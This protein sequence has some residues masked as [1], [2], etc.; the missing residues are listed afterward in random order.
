MI[1]FLFLN[2]KVKVNIIMSLNAKMAH[3]THVRRRSPLLPKRK[4]SGQKRRVCHLKKYV[5]LSGK[6]MVPQTPEGIDFLN[7]THPLYIYTET[8]ATFSVAYLLF[9]HSCI[10]C[11][12]LVPKLCHRE[13]L[14][15]IHSNW[16]G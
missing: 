13:F 15:E 5:W 10:G 4:W 7:D 14:R 2:G 9:A 8:H 12:L 6:I 1:T 16:P 11:S 3:H